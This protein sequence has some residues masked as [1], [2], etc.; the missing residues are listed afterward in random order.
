[1]SELK[2]NEIITD[3]DTGQILN[4]HNNLLNDHFKKVDTYEP[5]RENLQ[6]QWN[7][8]IQPGDSLTTSRRL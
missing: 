7:V 2:S 8:M 3:E 6:K 1:M 5:K 4:D